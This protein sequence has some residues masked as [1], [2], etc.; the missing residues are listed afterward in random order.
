MAAN[1]LPSLDLSTLPSLVV[2]NTAPNVETAV[3]EVKS[4][5]AA[6]AASD[7]AEKVAEDA[8]KEDKLKAENDNKDGDEK[9]AEEEEEE[10]PSAVLDAQPF[11]LPEDYRFTPY[12][13]PEE[14]ARM[15]YVVRA[16]KLSM[17]GFKGDY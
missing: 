2:P 16:H 5:G 15:T 7:E 17:I 8:D 4:A 3:L 11:Q 13:T 6:E 1:T 12:V 9:E 10:D 14:A